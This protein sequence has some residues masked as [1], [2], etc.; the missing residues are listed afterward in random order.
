MMAPLLRSPNIS[1]GRQGIYL[2][3]VRPGQNLASHHAWDGHNANHVHL[4]HNGCQRHAH[5]PLYGR[6]C[7]FPSRRSQCQKLL[8]PVLAWPITL[9]N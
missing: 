5:T 2:A 6:L 4:V 1:R 8:Y 9:K 3:R 7:G